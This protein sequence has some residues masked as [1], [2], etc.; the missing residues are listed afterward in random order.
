M[1]ERKSLT[2][3][4]PVFKVEPYIQKSLDSLILSKDLMNRR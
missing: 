1:E 4:V 2:V 3:V